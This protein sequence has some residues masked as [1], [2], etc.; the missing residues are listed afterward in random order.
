MFR[1]LE[2]FYLKGKLPDVSRTLV[3]SSSSPD[4]VPFPAPLFTNALLIPPGY[5]GASFHPDE[6]PRPL[7]RATNIGFLVVTIEFDCRRPEQFE[8]NLTWTR[9]SEWGRGFLWVALCRT[10]PGISKGQ[11]VSGLFHRLQRQQVPPLPFRLFDRTSSE[12]SVWGRRRGSSPGFPPSL[13]PLAQRP[14]AILGP[15]P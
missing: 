10:R 3:G 11:R 6:A 1:S 14:Q 13:R 8:E 9:S 4:L 12:C 5:G 15:R 2:D 7:D